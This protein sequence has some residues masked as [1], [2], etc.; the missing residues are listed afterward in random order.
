[1]RA[2]DIPNQGIYQPL[3]SLQAHHPCQP[4]STARI[5][6]QSHPDHQFSAFRPDFISLHVMILHL[7]QAFPPISPISEAVP[8]ILL[9]RKNYR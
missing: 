9:F 7:F 6:D 3:V 8:H 5:D 4:E 1:M 2:K